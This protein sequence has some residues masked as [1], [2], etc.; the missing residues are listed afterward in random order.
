MNKI[1]NIVK[2]YLNRIITCIAFLFIIF[3]LIIL[4]PQLM[5]KVSVKE[6][7]QDYTKYVGWTMNIRGK[8]ETL[9]PYPFSIGENVENFIMKLVDQ[10]ASIMIIFDYNKLSFELKPGDQVVVK[11]SFTD[12]NGSDI[13]MARKIKPDRD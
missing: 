12:Y 10:D 8:V 9:R 6:L 7:S 11:C 4:W 3:V 1:K 2:N 5:G 13:L